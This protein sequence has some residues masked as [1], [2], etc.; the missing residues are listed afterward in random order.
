MPGLLKALLGS[1]YSYDELLKASASFMS[2]PKLPQGVPEIL[3]H[4]DGRERTF[5]EFVQHSFKE[6]LKEI[7]NKGSR[8][9]QRVELLTIVLQELSWEATERAV[10]NAKHLQSWQHFVKGSPWFETSPTSDWRRLLI[11][12]Y[13]GAVLMSSWLTVLGRML[14]QVEDYIESALEL[15]VNYDTEIKSL[16]VGMFDLMFEKLS[17][18]EDEQGYYIGKVKDDVVNPLMDEQYAILDRLGADIKSNKLDL[19]FYKT[20]FARIDEIK[21]HIA[22]TV[23]ALAVPN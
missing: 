23:V 3:G 9:D 18:Y 20:Q 19:D 4:F 1:G 22:R 6:Y 2:N 21:K 17:K 14:Y 5:L 11:G 12:R 13:M 15:Y 7:A 8:A 10:K 16:G